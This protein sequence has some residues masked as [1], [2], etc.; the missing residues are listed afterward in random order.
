[1][2]TR[3]YTS[4]SNDVSVGMGQGVFAREPTRLTTI[5]G[6]CVAV[7]LYSTRQ[8]IGMMSHVV[9]PQ[10]KGTTDKPAKF[11]DTAIPYMLTTL[12][13][14]GVETKGLTAKI[15]GGA[16]MFGSGAFTQVG[17]NNIHAIIQALEDAGIPIVGRDVSGISGRRICFDLG[18]GSISVDSVGHPSLTI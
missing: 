4:S 9:L 15:V 17:E 7:T 13:S 12:K 1:M 2:T 11:A 5:L 8:Q 10:S 6:S 18:N 16:C 3:K 14:Q